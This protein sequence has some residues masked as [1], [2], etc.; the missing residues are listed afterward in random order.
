MKQVKIITVKAHIL[1]TTPLVLL[2]SFILFIQPLLI[3]STRFLMVGLIFFTL[4]FH[5]AV[6]FF[7]FFMYVTWNSL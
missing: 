2:H 7:V 4:F 1:L 3:N 5:N 6:K